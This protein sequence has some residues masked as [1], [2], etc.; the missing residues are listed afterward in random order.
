MTMVLSAASI[1]CV[2]PPLSGSIKSP[3]L[4]SMINAHLSKS[5]LIVLPYRLC[6]MPPFSPRTYALELSRFQLV[7]P[8]RNEHQRH[9]TASAVYGTIGKV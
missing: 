8:P 4:A 7:P 2:C 6:S 9:L 1:I 5:C 3:L